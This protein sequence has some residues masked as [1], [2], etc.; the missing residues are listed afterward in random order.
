MNISSCEW[1]SARCASTVA[2]R[3]LFNWRMA[4]GGSR[5][6][7]RSKDAGSPAVPPS[8]KSCSAHPAMTRRQHDEHR[9]P[10]R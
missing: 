4:G 1:R 5:R 9:E 7:T 3:G 8:T 10:G 6:G 2:L